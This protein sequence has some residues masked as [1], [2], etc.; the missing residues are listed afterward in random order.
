MHSVFLRRTVGFFSLLMLAAGGALYMVETKSETTMALH[1]VCWRLGPVLL[2]WWLAWD[3]I[4]MLPEWAVICVPVIL[5][6]LAVSR[7]SVWVTVP[8]AAVLVVLN[9]PWL[10]R[11]KKWGDKK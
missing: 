4:R 8:L 2:M 9:M 10:N 11:K 3:Y 6:P 7:K 1:G 5:V